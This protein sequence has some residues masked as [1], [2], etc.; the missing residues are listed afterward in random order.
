MAGKEHR[1]R[2]TVVWTGNAGEG[3][4]T[5]KAYERAHV[6]SAAAIVSGAVP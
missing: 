3:T 5:Y 4:S 6:I 1:Y 2:S